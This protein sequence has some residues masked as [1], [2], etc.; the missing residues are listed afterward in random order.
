[1]DSAAPPPQHN[2]P[3]LQLQDKGYPHPLPSKEVAEAALSAAFAD[4]S[5]ATVAA[6][7]CCGLEVC[8][9]SADAVPAKGPAQGEQ[10]QDGLKSRV[11]IQ[12]P[13]QLNFCW[14]LVAF[15]IHA[16]RVSVERHRR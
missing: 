14:L 15:H 10:K 4:A 9:G 12:M 1:M 3:H 2:P 16:S 8:L 5:A 11:E 7:A 6:A 13:L